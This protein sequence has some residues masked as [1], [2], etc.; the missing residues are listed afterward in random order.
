MLKCAVI[1]SSFP[2]VGVLRASVGALRKN[3]QFWSSLSILRRLLGLKVVLDNSL[4]KN[5]WLAGANIFFTNG[6]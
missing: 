3:C 4:T 5:N 6:L 1:T 2:G